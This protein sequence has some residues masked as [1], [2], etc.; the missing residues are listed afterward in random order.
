[1]QNQIEFSSHEIKIIVVSIVLNILAYV[2]SSDDTALIDSNINEIISK[3]ISELND[4]KIELELERS[5]IDSNDK[6][7]KKEFAKKESQFNKDIKNLSAVMAFVN[8]NPDIGE[9]QLVATSG[10]F[11]G[12]NGNREFN[13][14]INTFAFYDK[15]TKT[16]VIAERGTVPGE[17]GD[18]QYM[19]TN[20]FTGQDYLALQL[21]KRFNA[22]FQEKDIE[23]EKV[24]ETG[25][26]KGGNKSLK[27]HIF[28]ITQ[29]INK[30]VESSETPEN[31]IKAIN[32]LLEKYYCITENA[33]WLSNETMEFFQM[34]LEPAYKNGLI[35]RP[36]IFIKQILAK[37]I[38]IVNC[39]NDYVSAINEQNVFGKKYITEQTHGT[40]FDAHAPFIFLDIDED[41][42][43][44]GKL[45]KRK[46]E[47]GKIHITSQ[48]IFAD[49][50][51]LSSGKKTSV[52]NFSMVTVDDI[53]IN[54][55]NKNITRQNNYVAL[56]QTEQKEINKAKF[57]DGLMFLGIA[58]KTF[59]I[60]AL[61]VIILAIIKIP[62]KI[63]AA[64]NFE[65]LSAK[66]TNSLEKKSLL[67]DNNYIENQVP[68]SL[69]QL[70]LKEMT[71]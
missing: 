18:N 2:I 7:A 50:N 34:Q 11:K 20:A 61:L 17:W 5:N 22:E 58:I 62:Q 25:H 36:E 13:S 46:N 70:Q 51:N 49:V 38:I 21:R 63:N 54:N 66:Y 23:I 40:V 14:G 10:M 30:I 69:K 4:I 57:K 32:N 19:V 41:F 3:K 39:E 47:Y 60:K 28:Y 45:P 9:M 59:F 12:S 8:E 6:E 24:I 29:E 65:T 31:K 35:P 15:T 33:P 67:K 56:N 44:N 68:Q 27:S 1:M 42:V 55:S 48:D 37:N 43:F 52:L 26:S 64:K 71:N 53:L 16:I